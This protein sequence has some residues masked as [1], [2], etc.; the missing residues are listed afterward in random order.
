MRPKASAQ[1]T[2]KV[3]ITWCTSKVDLQ[4]DRHE[5]VEVCPSRRG[6]RQNPVLGNSD[7]SH[8]SLPSCAP[9]GRLQCVLRQPGANA[10]S[11][12]SGCKPGRD[13]KK[14]RPRYAFEITFDWAATESLIQKARAL[15]QLAFQCGRPSRHQMPIQARHLCEAGNLSEYEKPFQRP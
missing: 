10:A 15:A 7:A 1:V 12:Q 13:P 3:L 2:Q 11:G 5:L 9:E 14:W 8:F 4:V 6:A